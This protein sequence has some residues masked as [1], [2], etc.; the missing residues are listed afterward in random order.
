[1][2]ARLGDCRFQWAA[3]FLL[4]SPMNPFICN[5]SYISSL[6]GHKGPNVNVNVTQAYRPWE[7]YYSS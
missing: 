4:Y 6:S 1:M 5:V 2:I 7:V 3:Q